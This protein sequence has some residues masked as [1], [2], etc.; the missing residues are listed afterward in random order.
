MR[1]GWPNTAPELSVGGYVFTRQ[2]RKIR[3]KAYTE[4]P[5]LDA[6]GNY[7][8]SGQ[9]IATIEPG[10]YLGPV[11]TV[12]WTGEYQSILVRDCW[13]NVNKGGSVFAKRVLPTSVPGLDS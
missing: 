9:Y 13:I 11:E 4:P 5:G 8:F 3:C 2:H 10:T 6:Y 12:I 7:I 1:Q